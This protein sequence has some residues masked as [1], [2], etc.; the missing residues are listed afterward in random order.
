MNKH[1]FFD[2]SSA[3]SVGRKKSSVSSE[4]SEQ[5]ESE[6][7][8][9]G[10]KPSGLRFSLRSN[11]SF[12]GLPSIRNVRREYAYVAKSDLD[13]LES[14]RSTMDNSHRYVRTLKSRYDHQLRNLEKVIRIE[15]Q[16]SMAAE[17]QANL[18][19]VRKLEQMVEKLRLQIE[20][21]ISNDIF[22]KA[23]RRRVSGTVTSKTRSKSTGHL[24]GGQVDTHSRTS[25]INHASATRDSTVDTESML[26][27]SQ[28]K[29]RSNFSRVVQRLRKY[30]SELITL[31]K[32]SAQKQTRIKRAIEQ[33]HRASKRALRHQLRSSIAHADAAHAR[34]QMEY[35]RKRTHIQNRLRQPLHR[36]GTA[37]SGTARSRQRGL[38]PLRITPAERAIELMGSRY[39]DLS[40]E[41][42]DE[43]F[44]FSAIENAIGSEIDNPRKLKTQRDHDGRSSSESDISD[45][46]LRASS[47]DGLPHPRKP[48]K[49]MLPWERQN[50]VIEM[51]DEILNMKIASLDIDDLLSKKL[52]LA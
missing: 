27:S 17:R 32:S 18:N 43:T 29:R 33:R 7:D 26:E 5:T 10:R 6:K 47:L 13:N 19:E 50:S 9:R 16:N 28:K 39:E 52:S 51:H 38:L 45:I 20:K 36:F 42:E 24:S 40:S 25:V 30:Q 4:A 49:P 15:K 12:H 48:S 14:L 21:S 37:R 11:L 31:H 41:S 35:R 34:S 44:F 1:H 2:I 23:N 3:S 46:E 8:D 22:A